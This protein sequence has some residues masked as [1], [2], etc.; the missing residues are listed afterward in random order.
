MNKNSY[1]KKGERF[2]ESQ[3]EEYELERNKL[4]TL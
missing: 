2:E 3:A 4:S 1:F